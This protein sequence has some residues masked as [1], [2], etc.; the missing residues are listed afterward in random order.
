MDGAFVNAAHYCNTLPLQHM[1]AT[2]SHSTATH[3]HACKGKGLQHLLGA[4]KRAFSLFYIFWNSDYRQRFPLKSTGIW[5]YR[6]LPFGVLR[7]P[8]SPLHSTRG[9]CNTHTLQ[10]LSECCNTWARKECSMQRML[11]SIKRALHSIKRAL[12][13]IKRALY[14]IKRALYSIARALLIIKRALCCIKR[15][16]AFYQKSP[17]F[18][19]KSP[20]FCERTLHSNKRCLYCIKKCPMLYQ[21]SLVFCQ[22]SPTFCARTL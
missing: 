22:K 14:S 20:I 5:R 6:I 2:H 12:Y 4:T 15:R 13:S 19:Q 16:P 17:A 11:Y 1:T 8:L 10:H 9:Y 18:R 21:K 3:S 7:I